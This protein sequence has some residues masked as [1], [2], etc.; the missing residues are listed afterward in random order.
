VSN[1]APEIPGYQFDQRILLHPLA[2]LL[3]E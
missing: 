2:E 1:S 3:G